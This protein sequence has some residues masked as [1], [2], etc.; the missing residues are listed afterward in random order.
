MYAHILRIS[1]PLFIERFAIFTLLLI[2]GM[3]HAQT[4]QKQGDWETLK[5]SYNRPT[6]IKNFGAALPIGNGRIGAKLY[7]MVANEVLNLNEASLWSGMPRSYNN[8][9]ALTAMLETRKAL[10]EAEYKRADSLSRGMQGKNNQAYMP[11]G[12]LHLD[13]DNSSDYTNYSRELDLDRALV[14]VRYRS[15]GVNY[16]REFFASY[17]DQ[18][19]VMRIYSDKKGK[20]N[21]KSYLQTQMQG[22]TRIEGSTIIQNGRAPYH[23]NTYANPQEVLWDENKGIGY[24]SRLHI[25]SSG[26]RVATGPDSSLII[27]NADTAI[28]IFSSVTS[29]NGFDKDPVTQGLDFKNIVKA[30]IDAAATKSYHALLENHLKDYRLLFRR[31]WVEINKEKPNPYALAYQYARY[32]LISCSR[33]GHS[34]PRNEQGIW[35]RDLFPK[36]A[37]N[38]TLNENPNKYYAIA[39][40]GNIGEVTQPLINFVG[41]LAKSG[42]STAKI[43]YGF[44]GWVAHHNSDIWAMTTMA[45]GDPC[46]A[47]WPVGGMWLCENVWDRYKFTADTSYLRNTAYPILKGAAQF[48]LDLLVANKD[49]YLVTSPS[50]SPENHFFDETGRRVAVSQGTTMDMALIRTLFKHCIEASDVLETDAAFKTR[51]QHTLSKL[52]PYGIGSKGQLNEW[53]FDYSAK[54]K[55]WEPNHR[56]ISH[57]IA[58]WPLGE[59]NRTTPELLL[60]ARK[61]LELRKTG[62][63]HPD[64]AG[65]WSRLLDGDKAREALRLT[66]PAVYDAPFGGFSEMLMQSHTDAIDLLPALP[67]AWKKGKV[68]GL[69]AR[70]NYE[71]AIEW[72]NN[73]LKKANIRSYNGT[74]PQ[75]TIAGK[76]VD[77]KSDKR[78]DFLIMR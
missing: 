22:K 36:Y 7:G 41:A 68:A 72:E 51:L 21:F 31:L 76:A 53:E 25:R 57:V 75:V 47:L 78:V 32:N 27:A 39:E 1:S 8:P 10:A 16:T 2:S 3:L 74:T 23:V 13:F 49:G 65:M 9:N 29:F 35:N 70:G 11:L 67:K 54:L 34:A 60:A 5:L 24:Q 50:T 64:K 48:A 77:L 73:K 45:P 44:N 18:V 42:T 6:E 56:H 38:Y 52:L 20:V 15:E 19:I 71:I 37:S 28:L 43:N 33:P 17:P 62:G 30:Y 69:R 14:T 61:S 63:Y 40:P 26:G 59:I 12:N 4:S 66:Y 55:E 58:V 46:W